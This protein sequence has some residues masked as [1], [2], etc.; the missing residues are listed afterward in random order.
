MIYAHVYR[1]NG[2]HRIMFHKNTKFDSE[3]Q[4][5]GYSGCITATFSEET[6]DFVSLLVK[7]ERYAKE[8]NI[9]ITDFPD[10]LGAFRHSL[11][12]VQKIEMLT[13]SVRKLSGLLEKNISEKYSLVSDLKKY[14]ELMKKAEQKL[15]EWQF[16]AETQHDDIVALEKTVMELDDRIGED[17]GAPAV[18]ELIENNLPKR[19]LH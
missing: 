6:G 2:G 13:A 19:T 9:K 10:V 11:S 17:E 5:A 7:V 18:G 4:E 12:D 8:Q 15:I 14:T 1:E 16:I 3:A